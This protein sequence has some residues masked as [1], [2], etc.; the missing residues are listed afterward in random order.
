[1]KTEDLIL[2]GGIGYLALTSLKKAD[3]SFSD[4][5]ALGQD[6]NSIIANPN[7]IP[8]DES[9]GW[10]DEV[11]IPDKE[12]SEL[13]DDTVLI[14]DTNEDGSITTYK[15]PRNEITPYQKIYIGFGRWKVK[16]DTLQPSIF[17]R[18]N[19]YFNTAKAVGVSIAKSLNPTGAVLYSGYK[20]ATTPTTRTIQR[21]DNVTTYK[22]TP[23][24]NAV[25]RSLDWARLKFKGEIKDEDEVKEQE[26]KAVANVQTPKT[27][28]SKSVKSSSSGGSK[29][30]T[31]TDSSGKAVTFKASSG[32]KSLMKK[33]NL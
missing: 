7:K 31:T 22:G 20:Y 27:S 14:R 23:L 30:V 4:S 33:Y 32:F 6:M 19:K 2:I 9:K 25:G 29:R 26:H 10:D 18:N 1:M 24:Q 11:Y 3:D 16:N 28:T 12:E 15:L 17:P 5:P 21:N 8:L 13:D